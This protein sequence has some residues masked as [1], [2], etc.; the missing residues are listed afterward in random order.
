[1]TTPS[2]ALTLPFRVGFITDEV[3][4]DFETAL[5]FAHRFNLHWVELRNLWNTYVTDLDAGQVAQAQQLL[6]KYHLRVL[7]IDTAYLKCTL[8]GTQDQLVKSLPESLRFQEYS[9]EEQDQLLTRAFEKATAFK[10]PLLRVF[11]FWRVESPGEIRDEVCH[12]L[13]NAAKRAEDTGIQL[14]LENEHDCNIATGEESCQALRI[15][16]SK[17][18]GLV[19][20]P[21]NAFFAGE[22]PYP[23]GYSKLDASRILH[24]HVKDAVA[25]PSMTNYRFVPVGKGQVNYVGQFRALRSAGYCSGISLETHYTS[26]S[27][28]EGSSDSMRGLLAALATV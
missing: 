13:R 4:Q 2:N 6:E 14:G 17:A 15:V 27:K 12:Y 24:V 16:S 19:W 18:F 9:Y 28:E 22:S 20:D 26:G 5:Q 21:G 10:A 3:S 23:E 7:A 11:S 1:M 25:D 8:P